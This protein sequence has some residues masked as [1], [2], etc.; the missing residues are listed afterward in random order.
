MYKIYTILLVAM[1][2]CIGCEW[3]L[4]NDLKKEEAETF[5][6]RY[7]KLEAFFLT[8]GDFS[9]MQQMQMEY[10]MPTRRLIEDVLQLGTI[11][12]PFI[13]SK[14]YA[15]F[16]DS[17]LQ[18]LVADVDCQFAD[19]SDID[20]LLERAFVRLH[21][22][23]PA[24]EVPMVYTQIG[25]FD[26]SVC[27]GDRAL[28]ISLDKYL[29]ADYPLYQKYGYSEQQRALMVRDFIVPDCLGFYLL[30]LYGFQPEATDS[31]RDAHMGA[32]QLIVNQVLDCRIFDNKWVEAAELRMIS[33]SLTF[34]QLL[35]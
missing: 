18:H 19:M 27:V 21:E 31:M 33:D 15:F 16:Q 25:S 11:D 10:P 3:R 7:D 28:G 35:E 24:A 17:T 5:I 32:I 1:L 12:D 30:S 13:K 23:V 8:T 2:T 14:F 34:T 6:V 29:G 26:Q 20:V 22:L 4:R 9:T